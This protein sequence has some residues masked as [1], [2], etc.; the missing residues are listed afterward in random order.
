[1]STGIAVPN[2]AHAT[3]NAINPFAEAATGHVSKQSDGHWMGWLP[4]SDP[5][6]CS[7]IVWQ[8]LGP[9]EGF[10]DSVSAVGG[11]YGDSIIEDNG[12]TLCGWAMSAPIHNG[13]PLYMFGMG[14]NDYLDGT[15]ALSQLLAY[16]QHRAVHGGRRDR[17][18]QR[19]Q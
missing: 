8:Y 14:G 3:V 18:R 11:P 13:W 2:T 6:N 15:N 9:I 10:T 5:A 16:Q 19:S 12:G 1:M 17:L 7:R 4:K